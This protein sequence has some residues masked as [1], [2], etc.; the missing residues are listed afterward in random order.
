MIPALWEAATDQAIKGPPI[1]VYLRLI[2]MLDV[3]NFK[4]VKQAPLAFELKL[5]EGAVRNA[6]KVLAK[7]NYI[8]RGPVKPGESRTYRLVF[9]RTLGKS[10]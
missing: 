9:S 2:P 8:E 10:A 1:R 4:P 6:M 5:S 7:Q 3:L